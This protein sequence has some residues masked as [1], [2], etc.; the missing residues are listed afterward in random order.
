M[1]ILNWLT[2]LLLSYFSV[3]FTASDI[4]DLVKESRT[5]KKF[6]HPNVMRLIGVCIDAGESPYLVMPFMANGSLLAY[7]K[8]E[9]PNLRIADNA[10]NENMVL[11]MSNVKGP[12]L[13]KTY[14]FR[15]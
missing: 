14:L 13:S 15:F 4:Q 8:K 10:A 9:R 12:I 1:I 3:S 7:L 11:K 2:Y 6:D 5:M